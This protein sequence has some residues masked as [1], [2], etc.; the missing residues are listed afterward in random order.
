MNANTLF[1]KKLASIGTN[2][3]AFRGKDEINY[4]SKHILNL[5]RSPLHLLITGPRLLEGMD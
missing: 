2:H 4:T 1:H 5:H 3:I